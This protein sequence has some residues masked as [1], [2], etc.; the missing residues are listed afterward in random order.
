[1]TRALAMEPLRRSE[2]LRRRLR[3]LVYGSDANYYYR[4]S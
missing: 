3:G 4:G 2:G 1:M